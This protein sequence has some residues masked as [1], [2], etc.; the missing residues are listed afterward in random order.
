MVRARVD[1]VAPYVTDTKLGANRSS[2]STAA[3]KRGSSSALRG[4]KNSYES[5]G[6]VA[7]SNRSA[8]EV[9]EAD[10]SYMAP[11]IGST[12]KVP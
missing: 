2:L 11:R 7:V 10:T 6:S 9:E 1:P 4:G 3:R 5:S 8:I 12:S